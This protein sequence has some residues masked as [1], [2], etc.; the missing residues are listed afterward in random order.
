MARS[1]WPDAK[2]EGTG[3]KCDLRKE[4]LR[5]KREERREGRQKRE[6]SREGWEKRYGRRE[7]RED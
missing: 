3:A 5:E 1:R 2:I 4:Q 6:D 7:K